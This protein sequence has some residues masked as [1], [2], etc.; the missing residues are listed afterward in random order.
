LHS[1]PPPLSEDLRLGRRVLEGIPELELLEDIRWYGV[2]ELWGLRC[3]LTLEVPSPGQIPEVTEWYLLVHPEYPAGSIGLYP[4]KVGGLTATF[5]HQAFNSEGRPDLPWRNGKLCLDRDLSVLRRQGLDQEP[6]TAGTRLTWHISR[7]LEWLS[8]ASRDDLVKS[9]DYFELPEYPFK[10]DSLMVFSESSASLES[11]LTC[12]ARSGFVKLAKVQAVKPLLVV[13]S[14]ETKAHQEIL[15]PHWG[16]FLRLNEQLAT[17]GVWILL[18]H[19]IALRPWQAPATWGEL[20]EQLVAQGVDLRKLL[21]GLSPSL[22]DHDLLRENRPAHLLLLGFPVPK[23]VGESPLR[24]HWLAVELPPLSAGTDFAKGFRKGEKGYRLRDASLLSDKRP[25]KWISSECWDK[26]ELSGRGR[27]GDGLRGR[28]VA[29]IGAGALGSALAELL[30][31]GG[32]DDLTILDPETVEAGNLVRHTLGLAEVGANKAEA[33]AR[34]LDQAAPS[35][36]ISGIRRTF[37]DRLVDCDRAELI[38]DVTGD[39]DVLF[40]LQRN[41]WTH[42]RWFVSLWVGMHARRIYCFSTRGK[43][44]PAEVCLELFEPWRLLESREYSVEEPP[45]PSIGCWHPVFP[46]RADDIWLAAAILVKHLD[47]LLVQGETMPVLAVFEQTDDTGSPGVR[48][49]DGLDR[50]RLGASIAG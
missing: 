50:R 21:E 37:P 9:G 17:L 7:A 38:L 26:D 31:R 23:R 28:T 3:R 43:T 5:P 2:V 46:A 15:S 29:L 39:D 32:V 25:L 42:E 49:V 19:P 10:S 41:P 14:F 33:L 24:I 4:A 8:L 47:R 22:R 40:H 13:R 30:V 6:R 27:L 45:R 1:N 16:S 34:R 36:T 11:W 44:F 48:R 20:R 18:D 12:S 35:A